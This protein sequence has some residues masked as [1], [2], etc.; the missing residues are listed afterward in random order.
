MF[1]FTEVA[2]LTSQTADEYGPV[3]GDLTNKY[4]IGSNFQLSGNSKA[5]ACQDALMIVQP[6]IV[7][8]VT[9]PD[10]VTI[11]LK[12]MKGLNI[13]FQT[14][15]YYVYRNILKNS[16]I[17]ASDEIVA[18][19][20]GNS[21]FLL[22]FWEN[23]AN[24]KAL[25][26]NSA[27]PDPTPKVFG[28]DASM[29]ADTL[30]ESVFDSSDAEIKPIKVIEGEWIGEFSGNATLS[31]EIITNSDYWY[32]Q[33]DNPDFL[34]FDLKY[35]R[36]DKHIVDVTSVAPTAGTLSATEEAFKRRVRREE[37]LAYVDPAAFYGMH[38]K[39]GVYE[40]YDDGGTLKKRRRKK[41]SLYTN[42]LDKFGTKNRVYIDIRS[43]YG[44]SYDFY[45]NYKFP[46]TDKLLQVK[47]EGATA[48]VED[49]YYTN[50]WPIFF[51]SNWVG[52]NP[53][54]KILLKFRVGNENKYPL[55]YL[56]NPKLRKKSR[57]Q[58]F[59]SWG[60]L[61]V[62]PPDWSDELLLSI[63]NVGSG[64][65]GEN[66]AYHISIQYFR[67]TNY[68][69]A[70]T[71]VL[72]KD[73]DLD[74]VFGD[75]ALPLVEG[76]SAIFQNNKAQRLQLVKG[77]GFSYASYPE[78]YSDA[79]SVVFF[80][81]I[82][83]A[84]KKTRSRRP[85]VEIIEN[86]TL[87]TSQVFPKEILLQKTMIRL[88]SGTIMTPIYEDIFVLDVAGYT[89][90]KKGATDKE[91][92]FLLGV[93]KT[94]HNTLITTGNG[95]SRQHPQF[96]C[97]NQISSALEDTFGAKYKKYELFVQGLDLDGVAQ[98]LASGIFVYTF[99][100]NIF[101]SKDFVASQNIPIEYPDPATISQWDE[102]GNWN[103]R[104]H[105]GAAASITDYGN[106]AY[107]GLFGKKYGGKAGGIFKNV[108]QPLNANVFFPADI[109]S[110][111]M[112]SQIS[113]EK[114]K[115]P[116][117]VMV[118]GNGQDFKDYD[119]LLKHLAQNGFIAA[120]I[121]NQ[122]LNISRIKLADIDL[123][124]NPH[125]APYEK[126]FTIGAT[127]YGYDPTS[128]KLCEY[129]RIGDSY[130]P[131][132]ITG[133]VYG[134]SF[135]VVTLGSN[136]YIEFFFS[137][138]T[139]TAHGMGAL[140]RAN[141]LMQNLKVIVD[142]FTIGGIK[143]YEDIVGVMG[144]SRGGEA[145]VT[146]KRLIG[147]DPFL[148]GLGIDIGAIF[149]LAPTD[150]YEI[151]TVPNATPYFV[152]Y[153]SK[154]GD[155]D[156]SKMY[157]R[158]TIS[159]PLAPI[160]AGMIEEDV[161]SVTGFTLWDRASSENKIMGFV[162][163]ATHNGFVTNNTIDYKSA[164]NGSDF[165]ATEDLQRTMLDGYANSFFRKYLNSE[166]LWDPV[167]R[168][169][170]VPKSFRHKKAKIHVQYKNDTGSMVRDFNL[171]GED[172]V[173]TVDGT[174]LGILRGITLGT[175]L[176]Q[177]SQHGT[178]ALKIDIAKNLTFE[179]YNGVAIDASTFDYLSFRITKQYGV[180]TD[181]SNMR[182]MLDDGT[183]PLYAPLPIPVPDTYRRYDGGEKSKSAMVTIR[184]AIADFVGTV[185][186]SNILE[187]GLDFGTSKGVVEVDDFEFTN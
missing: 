18:S 134:N 153:G 162:H 21:E 79:N 146:A 115:Y 95:L 66:I 38:Y 125:Y 93:T 84:N 53:K 105:G 151:E 8:G 57:K 49:L 14:V 101:G 132:N 152:L 62:T 137:D 119:R 55:V 158:K 120:S 35:F 59:F 164:S 141:S 143:K 186:K 181:L 185:N 90:R 109:S 6:Q 1:F 80:T 155:V 48:F 39:I 107:L 51:D 32:N 136:D 100:S 89:K 96:I 30:I 91:D 33:P 106:N 58:K 92:L 52:T 161:V 15:K 29:V 173:D 82:E 81:E 97:F 140:G 9:D 142:E 4:E 184:V 64:S 145:A 178:R 37:I 175:V 73:L 128:Q 75:I 46:V 85:K 172:I 86:A 167:F 7:G 54:N 117:I 65:S 68:D 45:D 74:T 72:E 102:V 67:E 180:M 40:R 168:D 26:G 25:P 77:S 166:D 159:S 10:L 2:K 112:P 22:R 156:T 177:Y 149:S 111:T 98:K 69:G 108:K 187:I 182:V 19:D 50:E 157:P 114:S 154:D 148:S 131:A 11:I 124:A 123:V 61:S 130:P 174:T 23:W 34:R 60:D 20:P 133:D 183:G 135:E 127:I 129:D 31:F 113:A 104:I 88:N 94:E 17:N 118:H 171:E 28:F 44:Y 163:G 138:L 27:L 126:L 12:P 47:G 63:P 122:F 42:I 144:H 83:Y 160:T 24:F 99:N 13:P 16:L 87:T 3:S 41:Q 147:A 150:L 78:S 70:M 110:A 170:Y 76:T 139:N 165:V 36:L 176:D 5:I 179:V 103:Y 56:E 169:G 116:L 71:G 43:E 121:D